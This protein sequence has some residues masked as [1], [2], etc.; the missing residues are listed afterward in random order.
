MN[1]DG[2]KKVFLK[3]V[4]FTFIAFAIYKIMG[5]F[6][7]SHIKNGVVN[8]FASEMVLLTCAICL[9]FATKKIQVLNPTKKGFGTGLFV[10]LYMIV[11]DVMA[12]LYWIY[13]YIKGTQVVTISSMEIILFIVAMGMVGIAE[14]LIFRGVLLN[15]CLDFFGESTVSSIRKAIVISSF[16]FGVF[17]I[18]NVLIGASLTGSIVQA[19]NAIVLGMMLG[20]IYVRSGKN[21]WP[22]IVIHGFHDC[23]SFMQS[24]MLSG[25]GIKDAV[26]GYN[27]AMLRTIAILVLVSM[28]LMRKK[29]L[30]LYVK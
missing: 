28:F 12:V 27:M 9:A 10:G 15:G 23:V 17:H 5:T 7:L 19:I 3:T 24:G 11:I 8:V 30:S 21:L 29:K 1:L 13:Q 20:A 4:L 25:S 2:T 16:I 18:F 14:E 26:S 22:C 6:V